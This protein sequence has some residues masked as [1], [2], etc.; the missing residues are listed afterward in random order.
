MAAAR[1]PPSRPP[2]RPSPATRPLA[3]TSRTG[4]NRAARRSPATRPAAMVT[5][6]A[7]S[8]TAAAPADVP[9]LTCRYTALQSPAEP[10]PTC[11]HN[12]SSPSTQITRWMLRGDRG[13]GLP[14]CS[15]GGAAAGM[16][17]CGAA[18]RP[19]TISAAA[20]TANVASGLAPSQADTPPMAAPPRPAML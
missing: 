8:A 1:V 20:V 16:D 3:R 4:P 15:S 19:R 11:P 7:P 17:T 2:A 10:S 18:S 12:A 14:G 13:G 6:N 5:E 9:R